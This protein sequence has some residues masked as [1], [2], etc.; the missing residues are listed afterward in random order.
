MVAASNVE[1][2]SP[3]GK[4]AFQS[5]ALIIHLWCRTFS[6]V[7]TCSIIDHELAVCSIVNK[8]IGEPLDQFLSQIVQC[9]T[10]RV[11]VHVCTMLDTLRVANP[12]P[13]ATGTTTDKAPGPDGSV[14]GRCKASRPTI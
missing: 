13:Q 9:R 7:A 10:H 12:I 6:I 11:D 14:G 4:G 1:S 8:S 2:T 5:S 3:H